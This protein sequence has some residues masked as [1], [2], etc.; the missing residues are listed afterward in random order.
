MT[1]KQAAIEDL[2]EWVDELNDK[3]DECINVIEALVL[4]V[5]IQEI[6]DA[7]WR[8]RAVNRE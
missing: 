6:E 4:S 3:R 5:D 8:L 7:I 1:E 2:Q